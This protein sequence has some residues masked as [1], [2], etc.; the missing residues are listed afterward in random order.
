VNAVTRATTLTAL[1][2]AVSPVKVRA[3]AAAYRGEHLRQVP[4]ELSLRIY[5]DLA[6]IEDEW[7]AFE[8]V[9]D[10]TAF[11]TFD[12]LATWY[13]HVGQREDVHPAIAVGRFGDGDIAFILPLCVVPERMAKRLCW[14]GQELGDYNAPLLARDFS[15]RVTPDRFL[16]VW[17][18]LQDDMQRD[19]LL[20][21]D[22]IEFEKM[23]QKIGAQINPFSYLGVSPNA[24]GVHLTKLGDDWEKFYVAKR[25]SATRRRDRAKRRH[26]SEYG[27]I[28]FLTAADTDDARRTL[29]TLMDQKSRSLARKGVANIF[30]RPGHREFYLDLASN[31]KTR[32][33]VHISRVEIGTACAAANLGIVFGD[34]Y[35]HVLASFV[36][37]DVSHYG[38]GALHLRELMAHAIKLGLKRFDFTIGDEPYKLEWSD[39]DLKLHDYTETTSWR[40]LPVSSSSSLRRRIKRFIKQT[41]LLWRFASEVR[42]A[43]GALSHPPLA[44]PLGRGPIAPRVL[45]ARPARP[46]VACVM[47]DMDL[48]RPLALA[49]I[50]C[51][52]V[53]RPGVSSLYSRYAQSRMAWDDYSTNAD[54]LVDALLRF[55]KAQAERPVLFY[56]EDGQILLVSRFRERLAEA[57]RFVVADAT[58]VEDLLDKGRFQLLAERHG[59]PVPAARRFDPAGI[60][61]AGLGIPFP[62]IVKPLTRLDRWNDF[63]GLRKALCAENAEELQSLWPQLRAVGL[64]LLAQEFIPGAE[65]RIESYHCYVDQR[66]SVAGEFTGRKIRTQPLRYGHTTA[67]EITDVEDVRR[68]G[69]AIVEQLALSGVAKLDFKRDPQ[70][71]LRLLEINPRFNLWHHPGAIAGVNIPAMVYADLAGLPRPPTTRVKAG[72]HWCRVWKDFPAA[73]AGG[74]PLTTWLPWVLGCEAKSS[75]SWDDPLPFVRSSLHRLAGP[76]FEREQPGTW[77]ER[78]R[79]NSGT[80]P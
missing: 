64:E 7:R 28:R 45:P 30:A 35:Y 5:S 16:A 46:A 38:P 79:A 20:R 59:L 15:R 68:H 51:A 54:G 25:S 76:L 42:S 36:D 66:G 37:S 6:A 71:N 62:L 22:W 8:Q 27:E 78:N 34:C 67:L 18:E 1:R 44:R 40:G 17:R 13:R 77:H 73:R 52:V 31:P 57:F 41:P 75:L 12:W 23:P 24:S 33:L 58:L 26:M 74:V 53:T 19:P 29:E 43:I 4:Q 11:Q 39:T 32:H 48:L 47:G 56:Q 9:A 69:R 80:K 2:D 14:L 55:G 21:H 3:P 61:P 60:D 49:G 72:V 63:W 50:P 70:G 65:S 10:C